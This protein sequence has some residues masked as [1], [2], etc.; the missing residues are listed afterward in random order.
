M[1]EQEAAELDLRFHDVLYRSSGHQRLLSYWTTLRP[2]IYIFLLSRNV[3]SPDF[4]EAMTKGHQ[5]IVNA[6]RNR[7][8]DDAYR[9]VEEH[10]AFAY[11][12]VMDSYSQT[13]KTER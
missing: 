11:R 10:V 3:A 4:R 2:Q 1:N 13:D 9:A 7:L 6:I 12:R 8:E 5:M